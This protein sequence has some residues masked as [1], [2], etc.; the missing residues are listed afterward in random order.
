MICSSTLLH[1][2]VY[3]FAAMCGPFGLVF[4]SPQAFCARLL[5]SSSVM[6]FGVWDEIPNHLP[7]T[8]QQDR[9]DILSKQGEKCVQVVYYLTWWILIYI[10]DAFLNTNT[11]FSA[12]FGRHLAFGNWD[13]DICCNKVSLLWKLTS[14]L[15]C[16]FLEGS[17]KVVV[18][19]F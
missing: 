11:H 12:R 7:S 10:I 18:V 9:T 17:W 16:F 5:N 1:F 14:C 3:T 19:L 15:S 2:T 8:V 6:R 4:R 13:N